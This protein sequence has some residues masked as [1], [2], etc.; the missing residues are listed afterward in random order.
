ML[1]IERHDHQRLH[2]LDYFI[3]YYQ[4]VCF[5]LATLNVCRYHEGIWDVGGV[6]PLMLHLGAAISVE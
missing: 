5:S 4:I 2:R 6:T 1:V 3:L